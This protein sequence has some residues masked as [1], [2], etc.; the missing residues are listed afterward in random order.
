MPGDK[1]IHTPV[2]LLRVE[3]TL[4]KEHKYYYCIKRYKSFKFVKRLSRRKLDPAKI[5]FHLQ[6]LVIYFFFATPQIKLKLERTANKWWTNHSS[7]PPGP[8]IIANH[9]DQSL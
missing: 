6:V 2:P 8:I 1:D 9:L 3:N 4:K 5:I 7:K